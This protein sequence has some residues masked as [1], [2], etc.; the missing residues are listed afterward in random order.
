[1]DYFNEP[2]IQYKNSVTVHHCVQTMCNCENRW[3][4][5]SFPKRFLDNSDGSKKNKIA[6]SFISFVSKNYQNILICV[7]YKLEIQRTAANIPY[8][9]NNSELYIL[10]L[11]ESTLYQCWPWLHPEWEF[12]SCEQLYEPSIATVAHRDWNLN[13]PQK[14]I[15]IR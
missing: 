8:T 4:L 15:Q 2:R 14:P 5:E 10:H 9:R 6:C 11:L 7:R 12:C 13:H 1:M 3:V